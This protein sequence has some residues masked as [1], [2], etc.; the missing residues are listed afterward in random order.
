MTY[1]TMDNLIVLPF[2]VN[3]TRQVNLVLD[4][5][6]RTVILFGKKFGQSL[7]TVPG[8]TVEFSGMGS[9]QPARG[10][11]SLGNEVRLGPVRGENIPIVIVSQKRPFQNH[12]KIDGLIGYDI[13]TRFEIEIHPYRQEITF[14]SAFHRCLPDGYEYIPLNM[15]DQKPMIA[16]TIVFPGETLTSSVLVDTGSTLGLLLKSP[17]ASRFKHI[18]EQ[19]ILG[20]GLNGAIEGSSIVAHKLLLNTYEIENISAGITYTP[21]HDYASVGMGILK[22]YGI[23]INFVQSY[24]GLRPFVPVVEDQI[25]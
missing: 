7:E 14:R 19:V 8:R 25:L 13:F 1:R 6:C 24:L 11:V 17:D 12:M 21:L 2:V 15:L 23:I 10:I 22:N 20:M 4:T 9:G 16:S 3:G 18:E 5:S